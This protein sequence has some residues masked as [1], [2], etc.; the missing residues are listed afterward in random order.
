MYVCVYNVMFYIITMFE[1]LLF[2]FKKA[3]LTMVKDMTQC[4]RL[5]QCVTFH[6]QIQISYL[7]QY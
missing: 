3:C 1:I 7:Q 4:H 2:E 5:Q 6:I